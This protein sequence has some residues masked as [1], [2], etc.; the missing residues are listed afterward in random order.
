LLIPKSAIGPQ[1]ESVPSSQLISL[2]S[3]SVY[4]VATFQEVILCCMK[5]KMIAMNSY[6]ELFVL[7]ETVWRACVLRKRWWRHIHCFD[8]RAWSRR[9]LSNHSHSH[10]LFQLGMLSWYIYSR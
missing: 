5:R 1:H 3:A 10:V 7:E 2:R 4:E 9:Y 6:F 8:I